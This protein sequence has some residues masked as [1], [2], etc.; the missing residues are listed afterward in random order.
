LYFDQFEIVVELT[1]RRG[2][3]GFSL[4]EKIGVKAG[5]LNRPCIVLSAHENRVGG[6]HL[7]LPAD[8]MFF[9][10]VNKSLI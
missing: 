7:F 2:G 5:Y 1:A 3:R 6:R 10:I 8:P 9:S 4:K